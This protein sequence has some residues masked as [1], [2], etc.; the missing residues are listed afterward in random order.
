MPLHFDNLTAQDVIRIVL[1]DDSVLQGAYMTQAGMHFVHQTGPGLPIFGQ[2]E[3]PI[4]PDLVRS[5]EVVR[6]YE[7]IKEERR[8]RLFGEPYPGQ[9][10]VTREDYEYRLEVLA[11]AAA[12]EETS[13][14]REQLVRQFDELADT[15]HLAKAKRCWMHAAAAWSLRSNSPPTLRDLWG[16]DLASPSFFAKPR[17]QDFHPDPAERRKR[18][19]RPQHVRDDPR[20]IPNVLSALRR[21]GIKARLALV[22]ETWWD[23]AVIQIDL[24]KGRSGRFLA[25]AERNSAGKMDWQLDWGGN[26]TKTALLH[27][28]RA[29][30][31]PEYL[32]VR[33]ILKG[34]KPS[35]GAAGEQGFTAAFRRIESVGG[36]FP[37]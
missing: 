8:E 25:S 2:V 12:R 32:T 26:H 21:A 6:S 20:S 5:I 4:D 33:A 14:R 31:M 16:S 28:R 17:P 18:P 29:L 15:I 30:R 37:P 34:D 36:K 24:A 19:P 23:L 7:Q 13:Q 1:E 35:L 10:P 11:R 9:Q 3:G 27:R 22:G